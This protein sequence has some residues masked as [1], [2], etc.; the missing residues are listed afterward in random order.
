MISVNDKS[1]PLRVGGIFQYHSRGDSWS[2]VRG[3]V[4]T[5]DWIIL[6]TPNWLLSPF[7]PPARK[8]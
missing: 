5:R 6:R 8:R 7:T 4:S 1:R 3:G 2:L